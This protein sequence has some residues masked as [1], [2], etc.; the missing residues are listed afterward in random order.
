VRILYSFNKR[1]VDAEY[2]GREIAGAS[3]DRHTFVP[4]NHEG[5]VESRLFV[6]AQQLDNIYYDRHPGLMRMYADFE[7]VLAKQRI[8]AV[9]VDNQFPYHPDYLRKIQAYKVLRTSDGPICAYDRDLAYVHAY[10]HV[11]Y[12]SPAYSRDL[13]MAEKLRYC[14]V[15]AM[16]FWP[17]GL[18][19]AAFDAT[20]TEETLLSGERDVDVIFIGAPH[21]GKMPVFAKIM[22][23]LRNRLTIIGFPWKHT[24]YFNVKYGFP[25]YVRRPIKPGDQVKWYGRSKIGINVHNRGE[26]TVGGYRMFELPANGVMQISDGGK[27][28]D[29]FFSVGSEIEGYASLEELVEKVNWYLD[30]ERERKQMA[31]AAYRRVLRDYRIAGMLQRAGDLIERGARARFGAGDSHKAQASLEEGH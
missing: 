12:H 27:Y 8:D 22:K 25:G 26:F 18:F 4:F 29:R 16:D 15:K 7:A 21:L 24:A 14:G 10:D 3:N 6:R 1:G 23:A 9:I 2:W 5:Y 31:L 28:L 13:E 19:D 20:K 11:L 30:H 17:L